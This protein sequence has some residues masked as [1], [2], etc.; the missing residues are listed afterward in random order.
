MFLKSKMTKPR[1][2]WVFTPLF[3][4]GMLA[5]NLHLGVPGGELANSDLEKFGVSLASLKDGDWI[6]LLTGS[7]LSHDVD[8]LIRQL[9]LAAFAIGWFEWRHGPLRTAAM[10]FFLD[11]L[12]TLLLMFGI[13]LV[14]EFL[15]LEGF[16][17]LHSTF[18]VGMSTG[19]FGLIGASLYYVRWRGWVL[20]AGIVALVIKALVS[21]EPIADMAHLLMLPLGFMV[22]RTIS[23]FDIRRAGVI[24]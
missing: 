11:V 3:I 1:L 16:T 23:R 8:M 20:L 4:A 14:L 5:A 19:G 17:G 12:G 7:F 9:L 21:P 15:E 10:F 24:E 6:R 2:I 13:L 22:E 18:D